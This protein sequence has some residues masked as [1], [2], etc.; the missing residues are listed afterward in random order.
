MTLELAGDLFICL[1]ILVGMF[2]FVVA[3]ANYQPNKCCQEKKDK[4]E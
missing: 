1:S 4:S 2:T 3:N